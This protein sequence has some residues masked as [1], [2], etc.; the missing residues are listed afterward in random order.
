M[1][2][3]KLGE[4]PAPGTLARSLYLETGLLCMSGDAALEKCSSTKMFYCISKKQYLGI[5]AK[6]IDSWRSAIVLMVPFCAVIFFFF[7]FILC[8][9][10][11]KNSLK[12]CCH[13]DIIWGEFWPSEASQGRFVEF[14]VECVSNV[15][16]KSAK[17]ISPFYAFHWIGPRQI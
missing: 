13:W 7:F 15:R 8:N 3:L 2:P 1:S 17:W 14:L 6:F 5:R 11:L 16:S 10:I 9:E 12:Q 4:T